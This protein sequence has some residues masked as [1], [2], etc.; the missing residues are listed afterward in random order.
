VRIQAPST[1]RPAYG[2][3][4]GR[5]PG[6]AGSHD[7][8]GAQR[9]G[10][11]FQPRLLSVEPTGT[12]STTGA[13]SSA[14]VV[15]Q[16]RRR[17]AQLEPPTA[18]PR[19]IGGHEARVPCAALTSATG[20]P[21]RWP[22]CC[23][24]SSRLV[25]R[26]SAAPPSDGRSSAD[27]D[28]STVLAHGLLL[29]V[30]PWSR[31]VVPQLDRTKFR[32][33]IRTG[34]SD[35]RTLELVDGGRRLDVEVRLSRVQRTDIVA[36]MRPLSARRPTRFLANSSNQAAQKRAPTLVQRV[37]SIAAQRPERH[38]AQRRRSRRR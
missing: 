11:V 28:A 5:G 17:F 22:I 9:R 32:R 1:L 13:S 38:R 26:S 25:R 35:W 18:P 29:P 31:R 36:Q 4:A 6:R 23:P 19:R 34:G 27:R 14:G 21:R 10:R 30:R 20:G 3:D 7:G 15:R 8:E 16:P 33:R 37:G 12:P 24:P 2:R